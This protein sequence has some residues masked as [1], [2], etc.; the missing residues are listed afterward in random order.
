MFTINDLTKA[1]SPEV[2]KAI[3]ANMSLGAVLYWIDNPDAYTSSDDLIGT[4]FIWEE[5]P[6]G[7]EY[8]NKIQEEHFMKRFVLENPDRVAK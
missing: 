2:A 6:E 5:T 4:A 7:F 3:I 8:W 1:F